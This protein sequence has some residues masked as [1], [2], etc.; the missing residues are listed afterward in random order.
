LVQTRGGDA[1]QG[2]A[3]PR[4]GLGD[5]KDVLLGVY[6]LRGLVLDGLDDGGGTV[7]GVGD[8]NAGG[9][10]EKAPVRGRFVHVRT[11][12]ATG[13]DVGDVEQRGGKMLAGDGAEGV[14]IGMPIR[15][16]GR[17]DGR[18]EGGGGGEGEGEG[19]EGEGVYGRP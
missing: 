15:R 13:D 6:E 9:E 11:L 14:G 12:R 10:V 19:L 1:G 8:A 7:T 16:G 17:G 3:Q 5:G 2:G 18:G 4:H